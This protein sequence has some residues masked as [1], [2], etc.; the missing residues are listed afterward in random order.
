MRGEI[1][2]TSDRTARAKFAK[3]IRAKGDGALTIGR[4]LFDL[5][6]ILDE[7]EDL[8]EDLADSSR[9]TAEKQR[10]V[11]EVLSGSGADPLVEEVM[12]DLVARDWTK[13][14]HLAD[15]VE[16]IAIDCVLDAADHRGVTRT[17]AE[18]LAWIRSAILNL[19][20]VRS[21]L[22]DGRADPATRVRFFQQIMG[23]AGFDEITM[24]LAEH[25]TQD[26]RHRRFAQT[27]AFMIVKTGHHLGKSVVTV[28]A[29][30]PLSDEQIDRIAAIYSKRL[31][32]DVS[33]NVIV[34]PKIVGGLRIQAGDEVSNM[35]VVSQLAR[36]S[37]RFGKR[38]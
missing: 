2:V 12:K 26:L 1:S 9:G 19:P 35:T 15:A 30:V 23:N 29:A 16:D 31:G 14:E 36:L 21:N 11:S 7:N 28:T 10:L 18:E 4:Q 3:V 25:A 24:T 17:V 37:E 22:S 20:Q 13:A 5:C 27:L 34:D 38:A 33:V 6:Q 32:T 8:E